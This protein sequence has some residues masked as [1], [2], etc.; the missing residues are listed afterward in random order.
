[1]H[2]TLA[3]VADLHLDSH[4]HAE[5]GGILPRSDLTATTVLGGTIA[6]VDILSRLL[7][8]QIATAILM[9][10]RSES[11]MLVLGVGLKELTAERHSFYA[12]IDL[13]LQCL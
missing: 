4:H 11:R 3:S 2:E 12:F 10:N 8:T 5:E 7:A 9:K 13:A 6:S 1:M